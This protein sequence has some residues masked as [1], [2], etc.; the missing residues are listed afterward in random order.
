MADDEIPKFEGGV[1]VVAVD[2]NVVDGK[3]QPVRDLAPGDFVVK[4][5]G[6]TRRVVSAEFVEL[7]ARPSTEEPPVAPAEAGTPAAPPR[8]GPARAEGRR[9]VI[10]VDRGQL[11]G[12]VHLATQAV[13]R[14]LDQL[15]PEDRVAVFPLPS[16]PRVDFTS[17]RA[18]VEK[19]LGKIGPIQTTF[20]SEFNLSY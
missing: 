20:M 9:F 16:G 17:D 12:S 6:R 8:G 13:T 2:A 14:L 18:L 15:G 11:G 1:E 3:G 7:R 5:D 4:V 19:A 10:V